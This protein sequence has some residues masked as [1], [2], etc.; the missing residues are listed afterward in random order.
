MAVL[1]GHDRDDY[2]AVLGLTDSQF[3][4][5]TV[6]QYLAALLSITTVAFL[7]KNFWTIMIRQK[8]HNVMPVLAFY[9]TSLPLAI[10]RTYFAIWY[11]PVI[12]K[13]QITPFLLPLT[14]KFLLGIDQT[15]IIIEL[16]LRINYSIKI[17]SSAESTHQPPERYIKNGRCFI[18]LLISTIAVTASALF[19]YKDVTIDDTEARRD[20]IEAALGSFAIS[21]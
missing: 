2:K 20:F 21:I 6:L 14:L 11:V 15:W 10:L 17:V 13:A 18:G 19:I 7:I 1:P 12:A 9:I 8:R 3:V 4:T 16:Y 5:I